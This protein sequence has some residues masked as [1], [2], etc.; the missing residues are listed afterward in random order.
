MSFRFLIGWCG[1]RMRFQTACGLLRH[2]P[3]P[4]TVESDVF[5]SVC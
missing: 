5:V 2:V 1:R 4:P 3:M